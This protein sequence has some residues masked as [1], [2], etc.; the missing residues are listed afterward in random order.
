MVVLGVIDE[1]VGDMI[2]FGIM[3]GWLIY[4]CN[5]KRENVKWIVDIYWLCSEYFEKV[6]ECDVFE[7]NVLL[8]VLLLL[9]C[10]EIDRMV[11][12]FWVRWIVIF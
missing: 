1:F 12:K 7:F 2:Y 8:I 9:C 3:I 4:V 5:E 11:E 6:F 10:G